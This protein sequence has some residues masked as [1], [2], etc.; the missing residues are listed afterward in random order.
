VVSFP[1]PSSPCS[2]ESS[3][4]APPRH[5]NGHGF[6]LTS[7]GLAVP[8]SPTSLTISPYRCRSSTVS[9]CTPLSSTVRARN[10]EIYIHHQTRPRPCP[11]AS[12]TAATTSLRLK[13]L[14]PTTRTVSASPTPRPSR[15]LAWVP[16]L[17]SR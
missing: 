7:A 16:L 15:S 11:P 9:A 5:H 8:F 17:L 12:D 3:R 10:C 6:V 4:L 1:R 2:S 13:A 14:S